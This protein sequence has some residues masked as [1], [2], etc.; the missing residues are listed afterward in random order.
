[1]PLLPEESMDVEIPKEDLDINF[2]RA[3]GKDG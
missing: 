1:M 3:G 2:S